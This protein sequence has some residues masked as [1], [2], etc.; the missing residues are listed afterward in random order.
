MKSINVFAIERQS[1]VSYRRFSS[2][3][4]LA[5]LLLLVGLWN[6]AGPG[7]WWDEGWTLSVARNWLE[8]GHYGRLMDGQL[9]P[10][11]LEA[12]VTVT[13]AVA[14]SFRLFGVG[15]WQGRLPGVVFLVA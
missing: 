5:A 1:T 4:L 14:L 15:I 2:S 10:P 11:G 9:W 12:S 13:T 8:R 3:I 6:L 7:M